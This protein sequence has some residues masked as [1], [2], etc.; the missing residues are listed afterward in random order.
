MSGA[1]V[2]SALETGGAAAAPEGAAAGAAA[3]LSAAMA[4]ALALATAG[5]L[6]AVAGLVAAALVA[7]VALVAFEAAAAVALD[8]SGGS[9]IGRMG[10]VAPGAGR[11]GA[12]LGEPTSAANAPQAP[13]TAMAI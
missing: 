3:A 6:A 8:N 13:P 5:A 10:N 2:E 7:L 12:V 1:G 11:G 9:L 4:L